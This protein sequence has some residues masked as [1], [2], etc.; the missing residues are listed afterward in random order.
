MVY[1]WTCKV[2]VW[3]TNLERHKRSRRHFEAVFST[4]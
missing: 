4:G 1:C 3:P 2:W